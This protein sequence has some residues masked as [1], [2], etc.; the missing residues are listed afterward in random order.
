M[1]LP[2]DVG[3]LLAKRFASQHRDWLAA[4]AA[5]RHWPQVIALGLPTEQAAL[6]QVEAVR[7]WA[8]A[9]RAWRGPGELRWTE[10]RWKVLGTQSL[11]DTLTLHEPAQAAM[12][13][14]EHERWQRAAARFDLLTARWPALAGRLPRLFGVLA[15]YADADFQRLLDLLAWLLA[16]P[17]SGLYPRQLPLAGIDSKWMEQR[18]GVLVDL[19][20]ALREAADQDADFYA[21]SGL[22]RPPV[23]LRM[24]VLDARLRARL[25]GLGDV[26]APV[27]ELARLALPVSVVLIVENLQTGLALADL[28]GTVA[29][30]GL[31]Y[32]VDLLAQLPWIAPARGLYWGDID[33]HGYAILQRARGHLPG[34]ASVLMDQATLLRC[35]PLWTD[36]KVQHG[37][38]DLAALT[39]AESLV[40]RGLKEQ[41]WRPN[42]RLEQERIDWDFAWT[43]LS[44]AV[45]AAHPG[46]P[47]PR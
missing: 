34:L 40:Y 28:P 46:G 13:S 8:E 30:M 20:A 2:A 37:A 18:R 15:D 25:G 7:A 42:L 45:Q 29:F 41:R 12:W 31:G 14:G 27:E 4:T 11:P 3:L 5:D 43:A 26:T 19:L 47:A 17:R 22:R 38:A 24:R 36:E 44:Q 16:H 10:R 33:T 35:A 21:L 6:R 23:Q 32:G 39:V 1:K 9:W